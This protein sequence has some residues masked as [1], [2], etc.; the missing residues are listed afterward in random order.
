MSGLDVLLEVRQTPRLA[1]RPVL[2]ISAERP[3]SSKPTTWPKS[4]PF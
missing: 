3:S 4:A 1:T 2:K